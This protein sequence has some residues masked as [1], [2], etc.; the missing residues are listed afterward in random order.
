MQGSEELRKDHHSK[1]ARVR[2]KAD[3]TISYLEQRIESQKDD[4]ARH[5][6]ELATVSK[7]EGKVRRIRNEELETSQKE[8]GELRKT[9]E[10]VRWYGA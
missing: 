1:L 7:K 4:L 6:E 9:V 8:N 2:E 5:R 3:R 10:M